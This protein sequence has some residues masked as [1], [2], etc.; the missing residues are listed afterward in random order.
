MDHLSR[1]SH[2]LKDNITAFG[3]HISKKADLRDNLTLI[4]AAI[5]DPLHRH[6]DHD[7]E[8][9][10]MDECKA[11][12]KLSI[13]LLKYVRTNVRRVGT[14]YWPTVMR[15]NRRVVEMF[16]LL[17]GPVRYKGVDE[18]YHE[19]D[20]IL[21]ELEV[22]LVHPSETE[23]V[24]PA[25]VTELTHHLHDIEH[26][27][28][29]LVKTWKDTSDTVSA[30][31]VV[32]ARQLRGLLKLIKKRKVVK[33][34]CTHSAHKVSKLNGREDLTVKELN[35][36]D[37]INV[38]LLRHNQDLKNIN[39]KLHSAMPQ[40]FALLDEYIEA[41]TLLVLCRQT[42]LVRMVHDTMAAFLKYYGIGE[43]TY[44]EIAAMWEEAVQPV[45]RT[46]EGFVHLSNKT[47]P[48]ALVTNHI[49]KVDLEFFH[50][51]RLHAKPRNVF[52]E[53]A[54][55][56]QSY[57][58][59]HDVELERTH[60]YFPHRLVERLERD[61][62]REKEKQRAKEEKEK[63]EEEK[64]NSEKETDQDNDANDHEGH[65]QDTQSM[66]L[67]TEGAP[68]HA[69]IHDT[70]PP[71]PT[72]PRPNIAIQNSPSAVQNVRGPPPPLPPRSEPMNAKPVIAEPV[73]ADVS[74][75]EEDSESDSEQSL[76][77]SD[78]ST[79]DSDVIH[80]ATPDATDEQIK[81][82]YNL[83]KNEIR[84]APIPQLNSKYNIAVRGALPA[85]ESATYKLEQ[86]NRLFEHVVQT[87][88]D[89]DIKVAKYAFAAQQVGDLLFSAGQPI[90]ILLDFQ[91]VPSLYT[92]GPNWMVGCSESGRIGFVPANYFE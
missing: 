55:P 63:G 36:L 48:F 71:L 27:R 78:V 20:K 64:E 50:K 26:L 38:E 32:V 17:A 75:D 79:F 40:I 89:T 35:E 42:D 49:P 76:V 59:W 77:V 83:A 62:E 54:D 73:I 14:R 80:G 25:I 11:K 52:D 44:D 39:H 82:L 2:G 30:Q 31:S 16:L 92:K 47:D 68:I 1:A 33:I 5:T 45:Q 70:P 12:L 90:E 41:T 84:Q 8:D 37:D 4:G 87:S 66:S 9:E 34:R 53:A 60:E 15:R 13:K 69:P 23:V 85:V 29:H 6:S 91:R 43:G 72:V 24:I 46:I 3:G 10:I 74:E 7:A 56:L 61:N 19:F 57:I 28:A 18:Y 21:A 81:L 65:E 51:R 86:F 22:P 67:P 88:N 58:H